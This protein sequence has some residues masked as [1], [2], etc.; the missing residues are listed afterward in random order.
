MK[1]G[2]SNCVNY[3]TREPKA[4]CKVCPSLLGRRHRLL[5]VR[6]LLAK[7]EQRRTRN[8]FNTPWILLSIPNYI[9]KGRPPRA[10][11]R[12]E[13]RG[14]RVP[15]SRIRSRRN[16]RRRTSW[17]STT[18]LSETRS[19][20]RTCLTPVALRKCVVKWTNWRTKTTH[21]ITAEEISVY[22]NNWWLRSNTIGSNTMPVRHRADFKQALST[23][24][25]LKHQE[26]TAHQQRW[27][28]Y[29]SSWWNWQ[30]SW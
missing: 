11:L 10:P 19:S 2:T 23:L 26:E 27:K 30:E 28:S 17:V 29:S 24:R 7:R 5:H 25:Q 8:S 9:K 15:T 3:S 16:A 6:A 14:S 1:L 12:E 4:Q 21:H 20:A 13:A 18:G 22:R